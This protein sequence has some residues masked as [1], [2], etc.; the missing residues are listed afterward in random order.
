MFGTGGGSTGPAAPDTGIPR[1]GFQPGT[2]VALS[3][4]AAGTPFPR[5]PTFQGGSGQGNVPG[6]IPGSGAVG[7][8]FNGP[9]PPGYV[10]GAGQ[11]GTGGGVAGTGLPGNPGPFGSG[12]KTNAGNSGGSVGSGTGGTGAQPSGPDG[13]QTNGGAAPG[14]SFGNN[15]GAGDVRNGLNTGPNK[16]GMGAAPG[17]NAPGSAGPAF[18]G[19]SS[20]ASSS[21]PTT[22]KAPPPLSTLIGNHDQVI[23]IDCVAN[24]A[25]LNPSYMLYPI[26]PPANRRRVEQ[27]LVETIQKTMERRQATVR[28]GEPSYRFMIRLRV[29]A[30]G[31][32]TY[33]WITR[34]CKRCT[35]P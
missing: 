17:D 6:G 16:S 14:L 1:L 7:S 26:N 3:P 32:P 23:T 27:A 28:L 18:G 12:P 29:Q 10:P 30:D 4:G 9:P 35:F 20:W 11:Q 15:N 25:V 8:G 2:L 31:L 22:I 21:S 34:P 19:T 33:F 5:L 24:G 13:G